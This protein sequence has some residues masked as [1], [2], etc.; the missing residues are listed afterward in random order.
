MDG[1]MALWNITTQSKWR[2]PF[3]PFISRRSRHKSRTG[4]LQDWEK[5]W[6]AIKCAIGPSKHFNWQTRPLSFVL[7][8]SMNVVMPSGQNSVAWPC[9]FPIY[10]YILIHIF[11][12]DRNEI[13]TEFDKKKCIGLESLALPLTDT[14]EYISYFSCVSGLKVVSRWVTSRVQ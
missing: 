7:W 6:W 12:L 13:L 14:S 10:R 8:M 2:I 3:L 4:Q 9:L 11:G 5:S 1:W